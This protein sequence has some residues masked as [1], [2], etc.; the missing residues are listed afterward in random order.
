MKTSSRKQTRVF[1]T[2]RDAPMN[3][4]QRRKLRRAGKPRRVAAPTDN[5]VMLIALSETMGGHKIGTRIRPPSNPRPC[6]RPGW[7]NLAP[8]KLRNPDTT[9]RRPKYSD[10]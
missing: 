5:H 6:A 7:V 10:R 1:T 9:K 8:R 2:E 3:S 4:K